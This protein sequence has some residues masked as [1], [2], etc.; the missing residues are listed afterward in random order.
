MALG[1]R[2]IFEPADDRSGHRYTLGGAVTC[3]VGKI[4]NLSSQGALVISRTPLQSTVPFSITDGACRVVCDAKVTRT[5]RM[6][7]H[8]H[9]CALQ[10]E[11][12]R[13]EHVAALEYII[14]QH[15]IPHGATRR[16]AA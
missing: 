16:E 14:A 13:P 15:H 7:E 5:R 9:S 12:L 10:F 2:T 8:R 6:A 3:N 4:V 11:G 1:G